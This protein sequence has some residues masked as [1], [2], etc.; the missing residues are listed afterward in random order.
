MNKRLAR[1]VIVTM[2]CTS[3]GFSHAVTTTPVFDG[4]FYYQIGG[5]DPISIPPSP[6]ITNIN[7]SLSVTVSG[8]SCGKFDPQ[9]SLENFFDDLKNG[10]DDAMSALE[11]AAGAAVA[12]LP[13]YLLQ[14]A[15]PGLYDIFQNGLLRGWAKFSL[16]TKSCEQMHWEMNN[17]I[18]PYEKWITAS[19]GDEWKVSAGTAGTDVVREHRDIEANKGNAGKTWFGG[20]FCG[21]Q[22]QTACRPIRDAVLAGYNI[23]TGRA[24]L[25]QAAIPV[26]PASPEL[27][28]KWNDPDDVRDWVLDVL[29]DL[30]ITTCQGCDR[31]AHPGRGLVPLIEER[32]QAVKIVLADIVTKV[33]PANRTNLELIAAPGIGIGVHLIESIRVI[34]DDIER[35]VVIDR[36]AAEI[37]SAQVIEE[38]LIVRRLLLTGRREGNVTGIEMALD[39]IQKGI[40]ELEEEIDNVIFDN[41]VREEM[42]SETAG[43]VLRYARA[44][45]EESRN[46][47]READNHQRPFEHGRVEP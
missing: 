46:I 2:F 33:L 45:N 25:N 22:G 8:L 6:I 9:I 21:G 38:A 10:V 47:A 30:E 3:C 15:N 40:D 24:V 1:V 20:N 12:A 19:A 13:G 44:I 36:L 27:V 18:D 14:K 31:G 11:T 29:G 16:A 26:T 43:E 4:L 39:E 23:S 34:P 41:R 28:Q 42:V 5:A 37:A 17:G 35:G 7:L 32:A